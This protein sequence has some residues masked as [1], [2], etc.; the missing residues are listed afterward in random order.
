MKIKIYGAGTWGTALAEVLVLNGHS[1]FL[2]HYRKE[3]I[4][5]I[6]NS[7]THPNLSS[8]QLSKKIRFTNQIQTSNKYDFL[9]FAI[10]CQKL[11]ELLQKLDFTN[12]NSVIISASKGLEKQSGKT[13][14]EVISENPQINARKICVL[15]GPTHAEEVIKKI[16]TTIVA[17]SIDEGV[18]KSV[19]KI[20]SNQFFR[21]YRNSD[22]KGV[23]IGGSIKNIIAIAAGI[24][25]GVGFGDNTIAAIIV[26]GCEEFSYLGKVLGA[27]RS[28]FFGLSGMGDLIVTATSKHSRNRKVGEWIGQGL[29]ISQIE[30][31]LN[32]VAEGIETTKAVRA[33]AKEKNIDMPIC[34]QV[35][36]IIFKGKDPLLAM[37]ELMTRKLK[38]EHKNN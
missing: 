27:N 36:Q 2:W 24:C 11:R 23:E 25:K 22:I 9:I 34:F 7:L 33:L 16:P 6:Q 12:I 4:N 10:P 18:S 35:Y 20:F 32:M 5:Q 13:M 1:V 17:S 21:V 14:S 30:N 28:T 37:K 19:Q 29:N 3:F 15:Y 26:R 8:Y 38:I 31:N